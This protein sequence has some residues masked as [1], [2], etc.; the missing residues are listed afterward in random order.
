VEELAYNFNPYATED[1]GSC[2]YSGPSECPTDFNGDG[3]TGTADLL[4]FLSEFE[5]TCE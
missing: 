3:A 1:D 5:T 4:L 2:V